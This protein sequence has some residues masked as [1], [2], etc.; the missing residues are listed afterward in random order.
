LER[1]SWGQNQADDL[2]NLLSTGNFPSLQYVNIRKAKI[3]V[4]KVG[5]FN[6]LIQDGGLKTLVLD[7][8]KLSGSKA[9]EELLG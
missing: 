6:A 7:G 8:I 4:G 5:T 9:F 1:L 2:P 3:N